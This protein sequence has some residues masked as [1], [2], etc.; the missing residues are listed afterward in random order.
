MY[1]KTTWV[2]KKKGRGLKR[3]GRGA[4]KT[5]IFGVWTGNRELYM[6]KTK[7]GG[8]DGLKR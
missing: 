8:C 6:R 5:N 4:G 2:S 1:N 7:S 3:E